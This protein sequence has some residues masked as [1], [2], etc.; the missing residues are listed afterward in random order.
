LLKINVKHL[1]FAGDSVILGVKVKEGMKMK[2]PKCGKILV[3]YIGQ[4]EEEHYDCPSG[5]YNT[6]DD[7]S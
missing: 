4:D 1:T 2:C 7:K 3:R 6:E 5:D